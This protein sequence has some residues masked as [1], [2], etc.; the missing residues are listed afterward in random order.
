MILGPH[1]EYAPQVAWKKV[2]VELVE[3]LNTEV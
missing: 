1:V 2:K 3:R